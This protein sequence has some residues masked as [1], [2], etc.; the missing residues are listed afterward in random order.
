[1]VPI[2]HSLKPFLLLP[3]TQWA[4]QLM[5][6]LLNQNMLI[7]NSKMLLKISDVTVW[8][9]VVSQ[10]VVNVLSD[11]ASALQQTGSNTSTLCIAPSTVSCAAPPGHDAASTPNQSLRQHLQA[12]RL[13][14]HR[15]A[16]TE[17]ATVAVAAPAA[18]VITA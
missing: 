12:G 8:H 16:D 7:R 18:A 1:M 3:L 15:T 2:K 5:P 11:P 10:S 4:N 14:E 17:H 9:T 13:A 6:L